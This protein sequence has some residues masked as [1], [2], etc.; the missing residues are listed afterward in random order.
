[1]PFAI[2]QGDCRRSYRAPEFATPRTI[3]SSTTE[4]YPY[5]PSGVPRLTSTFSNSFL[6]T[7]LNRE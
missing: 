6:S 2:S 4:H 3:P 5:Y 1:M 7:Y